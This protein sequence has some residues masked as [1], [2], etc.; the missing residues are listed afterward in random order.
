MTVSQILS[1]LKD[2]SK[3]V[4]GIVASR[5]IEQSYKPTIVMTDSN[6]ELLNWLSKV[7]LRI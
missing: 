3:G 5:L 1:I 4:L 6:E 7:S 2:W